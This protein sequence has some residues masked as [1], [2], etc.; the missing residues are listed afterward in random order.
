MCE[1]AY[2][3]AKKGGKPGK[4]EFANGGTLFLDEIGEMPINLQAKLLRA[5]ETKTIT[6]IGG[7]KTIQVDIKI[8]A[9][10]NVDL[11]KLV[12]EGKFRGDLYYRLN[13]LNLKIPSLHERAHDKII[14]AEYFI[15]N[16][17]QKQT[18]ST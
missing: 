8:I 2:T 10:T 16:W 4:F 13:V 18:K 1:F 15:K 14:L 5:I 11:Q 6:R 12:I 9:A 7:N 3:G 17:E